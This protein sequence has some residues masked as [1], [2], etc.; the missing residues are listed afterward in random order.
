MDE[1]DYAVKVLSKYINSEYSRLA[2]HLPPSS[3]FWGVMEEEIDD[4]VACMPT[5]PENSKG[6]V[7]FLSI[8]FTP[9][10]VEEVESKFDFLSHSSL[11]I[12]YTLR[13]GYAEFAKGVLADV[14]ESPALVNFFGSIS[15][16]AESVLCEPEFISATRDAKGAA[17][18]QLPLHASGKNDGEPS[19]SDGKDED[20]NERDRFR[21]FDVEGGG[22]GEDEG[23]L[24][25]D[26]FP[27]LEQKVIII[28]MSPFHTPPNGD[29]SKTSTLRFCSQEFMNSCTIGD[30]YN[31]KRLYDP[32][33][34]CKGHVFLYHGTRSSSLFAF[35]SIGIVPT[36]RRNEFSVGPSFYVSNSLRHAY[37]HPLHK[38]VSQGVDPVSV[39]VFEVD[40]AVLHGDKSPEGEATSF[41]VKWFPCHTP[42][43]EKW[44]DFCRKNL[45]MK[46]HPHDYDVVIGPICIRR[47]DE[48][49]RLYAELQGRVRLIQV[50]LCSVRAKS[51]LQK[52]F[53]LVYKEVRATNVS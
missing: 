31:A 46:N 20:D 17:P 24:V 19:N 3:D 32:G 18:T 37:E 5:K 51:W 27:E 33:Y 21:E 29:Y 25:G 44:S 15:L 41:K 22:D 9:Q 50:A 13:K 6:C 35:K 11:G 52:C 48:F 16:E 38:H 43:E 2:F 10:V 42:V 39:L 45:D 23:I 30:L 40:V 34:S 12:E 47:G 8:F 4:K 14:H 53:K 1:S 49:E 28:Q 7:E 26:Q 36:L